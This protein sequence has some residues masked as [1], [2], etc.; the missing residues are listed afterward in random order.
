[1]KKLNKDIEEKANL[2]NQWILSQEVVQEYQK[3][4]S[5][6]KENQQYAQWEN[7]LKKMQQEIVQCK[8]S[9]IDCE[10]LINEYQKKKKA[11][12]E[13]PVIYNYLALKQ[14]V[15]ILLH[16]IQ[17]DI[18]QQLKKKVDENDKNLYNFSIK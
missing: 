11:F 16:Q 15:N 3:Y 14:D 9:Q 10:E 8:H 1:M 17:N 5:L 7:E 18:N 6:I 4:A 12:D 13:N 2:L